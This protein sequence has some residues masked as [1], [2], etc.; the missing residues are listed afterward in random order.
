MTCGFT[1]PGLSLKSTG[2]LRIHVGDIFGSHEVTLW[3]TE[4]QASRPN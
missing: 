1:A 3:G 4:K 2:N